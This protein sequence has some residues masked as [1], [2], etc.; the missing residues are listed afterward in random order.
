MVKIGFKFQQ[1][2]VEQMT[3]VFIWFCHTNLAPELAA[4]TFTILTN[5]DFMFSF[6]SL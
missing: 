4:L 6:V 1:F 5:I 2:D 3:E